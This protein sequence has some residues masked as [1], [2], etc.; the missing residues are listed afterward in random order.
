MKIWVIGRHYPAVNNRMRGSFEIEQAKMLARGGHNVTY[1]AIIFHPYKKIHSWGFSSWN[2]DGIRVCG[3]SCPFFPEKM[4]VQMSGFRALVQKK[5]MERVEKETGLPD[6]IHV[7]YPTMITDPDVVLS[8]QKKGCVVVCTEHWT[9]VQAKT[10]NDRE[11]SQLTKYVK[12]ADGFICV[13][14]PLKKSVIDLTKTNKEIS[15]IPNVV[16][17]IFN[18]SNKMAN[19]KRTT[20]EFITAGRLV[21]VKQIDKVIEAFSQLIQDNQ[22]V[23]LTIIGTGEEK[24]MLEI[25]TQKL[26]LDNY[27]QFT[28]TLP[29][30]EVAKRI[31][32]ADCLICYSNLETFGV[33]I[34]EA[35]AS[36]IP[37][38][39]SDALGF[40][41]YW[42]NSV[43]GLG[44]IV[45]QNNTAELI[46]KMKSVINEKGS[47]NR[48]ELHQFAVDHFSEERVRN[49]IEDL[50]SKAMSRRKQK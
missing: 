2:E 27:I 17:K 39:S 14:S 47:Y 22:D 5:A 35:W 29:R 40:A 50:Y 4:N 3:Y 24:E 42:D 21:K 36:G 38:I 11:K 20:F 41:E 28:G 1:I 43:R 33:P 32:N 10:I 48:A 19:D 46:V 18:P 6:V 44:Y 30:K 34:I 26:H 25:L 31:A 12:D 9:S 15:I 16:E 23:H 13:G 8:Y 7:H 37:A 49:Q 45:N